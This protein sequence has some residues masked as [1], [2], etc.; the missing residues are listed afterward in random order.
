MTSQRAKGTVNRYR[1]RLEEVFGRLTGNRHQ[2]ASGVARQVKG[3]AQKGIADIA[4]AV[5]TPERK[6]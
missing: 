2:Q 3:S 5:R 4:D 6:G 1:G